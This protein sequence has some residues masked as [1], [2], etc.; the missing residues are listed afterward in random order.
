MV[1]DQQ[2][3]KLMGL[4]SQGKNCSLS[5]AK[6]GMDVKTARKY[7]LKG[8]LP[9]DLKTPHEW[10]TRVEVFQEVWEEILEKLELNPGL[11]AKT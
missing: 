2:V 11:A 9:S 3:R 6:S 10:R 8:K 7:R 4:L 1:T 5:A